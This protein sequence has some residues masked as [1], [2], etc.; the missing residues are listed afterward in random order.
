MGQNETLKIENPMKTTEL[1]EVI[2]TNRRSRRAAMKSMLGAV[3]GVSAA[4]AVTGDAE[5]QTF[6]S[7]A[8]D[9]AVLNFAL[10]LEYL[11]GEY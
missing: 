8:T 10:N 1:M 4:A 11:E 7:P 3:A 6:G 5:A 9:A 2:D